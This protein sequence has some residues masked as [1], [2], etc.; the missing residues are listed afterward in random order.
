MIWSKQDSNNLEILAK[1]SSKI[2]RAL[3]K[4][5]QLED[6]E[7]L[8]GSPIQGPIGEVKYSEYSPEDEYEKELEEKQTKKLAIGES[9]N[10]LWAEDELDLEDL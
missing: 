5:A 3:I 1:N 2:A 8:E 9:S 7:F 10:Q 4:I 6:D